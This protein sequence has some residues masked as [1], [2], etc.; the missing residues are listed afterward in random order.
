MMKRS[1]LCFG[2]LM[3]LDGPGFSQVEKAAPAFYVVLNS[4]TKN[5]TVADKLP[6]TDT[7]NITVA[8]DTIYRTRAEAETAIKTLTPCN[9]QG[10]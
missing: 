1:L 7:P 6:R 5:C 2:F 9:Q 4:L 3:L 8:S 10:R